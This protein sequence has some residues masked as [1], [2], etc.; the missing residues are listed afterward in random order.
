MPVFHSILD[1]LTNVNSNYFT[2]L[3]NYV[4]FY[5]FRQTV[6]FCRHL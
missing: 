4:V 6:A 3:L 2:V 5:G 1:N